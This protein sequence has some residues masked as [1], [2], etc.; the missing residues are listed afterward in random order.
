MMA[1][2][3]DLQTPAFEERYIQSCRIRGRSALTCRNYQQVFRE[4]L[5]WSQVK[6][7]GGLRSQ[8]F[9]AYLYYLTME[10]KLSPS[11]IRLRFAALRSLYQFAVKNRILEHNPVKGVTLPKLKRKL[12]VFMTEEH[13]L[14]LLKAPE[15][16]W[17]ALISVKSVG[18]PWKQWQ[19]YRDQAWLEVLYSTGIRL[20]ELCRLKKS[21]LDMESGVIRVFGKGA[22]ERMAVLGKNALESLRKYQQAVTP[23]SEFLWINDQGKAL[24]HR[25]IQFLLKEYLKW[26]GL[27]ATLS[28]HKIRHSFATH[29]LNHG[30]DLRSVQELLGHAQMTTT[31]IYTSISTERLK[32]VYQKAH[33]RA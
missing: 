11:S 20:Q 29:L 5:A 22:K 31:Q 24:A 12:P 10:K 9:K 26:A 25:T 30:A 16:K 7:W 21:D 1:S 14:D 17:N 6:T 23:S 4:F 8:D 13:V 15:K 18:R 2:T 33:P 19:M 32:Q 27:P 3:N 28:P